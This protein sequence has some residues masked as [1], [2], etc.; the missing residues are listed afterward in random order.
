[1]FFYPALQPAVM[2]RCRTVVW[3]QL[4]LPLVRCFFS[5]EVFRRSK[6]RA[7]V[8]SPATEQRSKLG[9][10]KY[11]QD[12]TVKENQVCT[13]VLCFLLQEIHTTEFSSLN[14]SSLRTIC[15]VQKPTRKSRSTDRMC[16][17]ALFRLGFM[18]PS[19]SACRPAVRGQ[20]ESHQLEGPA[21]GAKAAGRLLPGDSA[22]R[23]LPL[24]AC[25]L[26]PSLAGGAGAEAA[27]AGGRG[28][29]GVSGSDGLRATGP[30][31][32][33]AGG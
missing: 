27:A 13:C 17:R 29:A 21:G 7:T 15:Y 8:L 30:H 16:A 3:W 9:Q 11:R 2:P 18:R 26:Q 10:R 19:S 28:A 6:Q 4:P 23:P 1:M 20:V 32:V 22:R 25:A 24:Q 12:R 33:P 31:R 5:G 14:T